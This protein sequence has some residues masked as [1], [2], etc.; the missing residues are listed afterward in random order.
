MGII[1]N[2][3]TIIIY[4]N[5]FPNFNPH[6]SWHVG[7]YAFDGA[8]NIGKYLYNLI[9][10][11]TR[12]FIASLKKGLMALKML[13]PRGTL[14]NAYKSILINA[15]QCLKTKGYLGDLIFTPLTLLWIFW[16]L[17][18]PYYLNE[19]YLLIPVF[20]IEIFLIIKGYSTAKIAWGNIN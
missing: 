9:K 13:L 3:S 17:L 2:I 15:G 14:F 12:M 8:F 5:Y 4:L 20:P 11:S 7:W 19:Y 18:I 16:P 1:S 6:F 10:P